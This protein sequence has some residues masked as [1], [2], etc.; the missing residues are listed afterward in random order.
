LNKTNG[1][2]KLK[3]SFLMRR[4]EYVSVE[5]AGQDSNGL[6]VV[7][8][9]SYI[10]SGR[11]YLKSNPS[12]TSLADDKQTLSFV[13]SRSPPGPELQYIITRCQSSVQRKPD[14]SSSIYIYIYIIIKKQNFQSFFIHLFFFCRLSLTNSVNIKIIFICLS[15]TLF[16]V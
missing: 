7:I 10:S 12:L 9:S 15:T 1:T 14:R 11:L 4:S 2:Q 3:T 6:A 16:H 13:T 8:M 5:L